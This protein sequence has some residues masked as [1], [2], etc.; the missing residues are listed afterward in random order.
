MKRVQ[1]PGSG[2]NVS[3]LDNFR[4]G[5]N[6][7]SGI[8]WWNIYVASSSVFW[9]QRWMSRVVW[10]IKHWYEITFQITLAELLNMK[11][12]I[13]FGNFQRA[14]SKTVILGAGFHGK[15]R[16]NDGMAC[17]KTE[18][19]QRFLA[20]IA[21]KRKR[22]VWKESGKKSRFNVIFSTYWDRILLKFLTK[23]LYLCPGPKIPLIL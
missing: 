4:K 14:T 10:I 7:R 6:K 23:F 8:T 13:I 22:K 9:H 3:K 2:F 16:K 17:K 20:K 1:K 18:F 21:K 15:D 12:S 11:R 5:S 19:P